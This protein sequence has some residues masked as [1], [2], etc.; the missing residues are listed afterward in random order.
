MRKSSR[1]NG[2]DD[3]GNEYEVD[4]KLNCVVWVLLGGFYG[5]DLSMN[6]KCIYFFIKY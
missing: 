5:V 2:D 1:I 4:R 3:D 6:M